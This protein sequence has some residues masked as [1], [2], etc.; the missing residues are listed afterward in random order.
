V[1]QN[2]PILLSTSS[3]KRT[4]TSITQSDD[5]SNVINSSREFK[6][7]RMHYS[8]MTALASASASASSNEL[9]SE[10]D[11]SDTSQHSDSWTNRSKAS[12]DHYNA[13]IRKYNKMVVPICIKRLIRK[14]LTSASFDFVRYLINNYI[15]LIE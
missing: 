12:V 14:Q 8:Y 15:L 6:R 1:L 11:G 3:T 4:Q 7:K 13:H 10:S 5:F 9:E 2:H